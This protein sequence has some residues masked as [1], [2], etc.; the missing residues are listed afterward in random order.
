MIFSCFRRR[1]FQNVLKPWW[2]VYNDFYPVTT[3]V[4]S[5]LLSL[6]WRSRLDPIVC[7]NPLKPNPIYASLRLA[8][9]PKCAL[10]ARKCIPQ[11]RLKF[12]IINC[13]FF[14]WIRPCSGTKNI[15]I[16]INKDNAD[17]VESLKLGDTH[18]G[19]D[20]ASREINVGGD[21]EDTCEAMSYINEKSQNILLKNIKTRVSKSLN[22]SLIFEG[23]KDIAKTYESVINSKRD[24]LFKRFNYD[25][26][27]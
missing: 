16:N 1:S 2:T 26:K 8:F 9:H 12:Q 25:S 21:Y 6:A 27:K 17:T 18:V 14:L 10:S 15:L 5:N 13:Q 22:K 20:D 23:V 24:R 3:E 11:Y 19:K 4:F 7:P